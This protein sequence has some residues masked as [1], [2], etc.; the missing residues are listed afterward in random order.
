MRNPRPLAPKSRRAVAVS[1]R[2]RSGARQQGFSTLAIHAGQPPD[3][4]TGAVAPPVFATSTYA[5]TA[6]GRHKGFE[7]SRTKNPT[8]LMLERNLA[9]LEGGRFGLAFASG[10]A[11]MNTVLN[12]LSAGDHVVC[13]ND[14]YGGT[15]RLLT[16]VF[17]ACGL[18]VSFVDTT[19]PRN[20]TRAVRPQTR[21]IWI[22]TPTNPLLR[23]TDIRAVAQIARRRKILLAVDN[24]FATPYLQRPLA[25]GADIVAQST[26]KYL[27]GHSDVVGGALVTNDADLAG[28]LAFYQNAVGA[29]PSPFDCFLVLRGTKTLAVR[30]ER[31]CEN[32]SKV[33][34]WLSRH[35]RVARVLYPGL[36]SHPQHALAARQMRGFGG[37]ISFELVGGATRDAARFVSA[38]RLFTLGESLGGVESLIVLPCQA[39]HVSVPPAERRRAGLVDHLI[40]LSVGIEDA[41][42]LIAD[43]DQAFARVFGARAQAARSP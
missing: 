18:S 22:E 25:L 36:P 34:L 41:Q 16:K 1:P 4:T 33:A 38:T 28:R 12:L 21:L 15:H 5:Q 20:V 8:R 7:Y 35:P 37:M 30:M 2:A 39:T 11:A 13:G 24:T 42:D 14:V 10:M 9:A 31:H 23:I 43:L 17:D 19:D 6:P 29:V 27:G 26:T 3:P 32:A 40:R